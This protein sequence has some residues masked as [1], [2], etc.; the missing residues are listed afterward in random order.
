MCI[1]VFIDFSV[2]QIK[3]LVSCMCLSVHTITFN[4]SDLCE[5]YLA[6]WYTLFVSTLSSMVR[7][8]GHINTHMRK[9]FFS[10]TISELLNVMGLE[11]HLYTAV[12]LISLYTLCA[13]QQLLEC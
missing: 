10:V 12:H 3:Q 4:Q 7:V 6:C 9:K 8:M 13:S 11:M 2:V 5:R 1:V